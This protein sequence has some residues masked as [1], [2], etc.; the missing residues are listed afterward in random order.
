MKTIEDLKTRYLARLRLESDRHR[1]SASSNAAQGRGDDAN[2]DKIRD[3]IV[4]IFITLAEA[5]PGKDYTSYCQGYLAR[6][7]TIPS[8]WRQRLRQAQAHGDGT[9]AAIEMVKLETAEGLRTLFLR[10][11]EAEHD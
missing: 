7:D 2:L 5:T 6:F 1:Q 11:M 3:N 10:E 9:T 8:S 4:N